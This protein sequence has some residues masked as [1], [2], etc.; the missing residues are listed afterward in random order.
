MANSGKNTNSSQFF[1]VLTEDET[2]LKKLSGKYVI[3]GQVGAL[4]TLVD[5]LCLD[6]LFKVE[7]NDEAMGVLMRLNEV[8]T[9]DG[10]PNT[11]VWIGACGMVI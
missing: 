2:K 11:K 8:G 7:L 3:F 1:I 4:A 6:I 9:A 10:K 5:L